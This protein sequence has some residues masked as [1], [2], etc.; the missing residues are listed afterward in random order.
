MF[1]LNNSISIT[2]F[3]EKGFA[4]M[5]IE[6]E[7]TRIGSSVVLCCAAEHKTIRLFISSRK[8]FCI[9]IGWIDGCRKIVDYIKRLN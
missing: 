3:A 2:V 5:E 1:G 8:N 9:N 7:R 6:S 4:C